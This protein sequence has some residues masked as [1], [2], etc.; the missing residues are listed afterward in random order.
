MSKWNRPMTRPG[1]DY[2]RPPKCALC[3]KPLTSS[4]YDSALD[5]YVHAYN[6]TAPTRRRPK[7]AA[8]LTQ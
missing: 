7:A 8:G 1:L 3:G 4:V 2:F 6:C 5:A